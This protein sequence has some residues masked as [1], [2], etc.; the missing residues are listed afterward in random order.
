MNLKC[1]LAYSLSDHFWKQ[2]CEYYCRSFAGYTY[3]KKS[4]R[5]K[6]WVVQQIEIPV[7]GPAVALA[8]KEKLQPKLR[9]AKRAMSGDL[10]EGSY[11]TEKMVEVAEEIREIMQQAEHEKV[12]PHMDSALIADAKMTITALEKD[13]LPEELMKAM[14]EISQAFERVHAEGKDAKLGDLL[15]RVALTILRASD[16]EKRSGV[17]VDGLHEARS[18]FDTLVRAL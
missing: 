15:E 1:K 9:L 18:L 13:T 16:Y 4:F 2:D 3:A 11:D 8:L 10:K 5:H 6:K 14:A 12:A 17:E 7:D